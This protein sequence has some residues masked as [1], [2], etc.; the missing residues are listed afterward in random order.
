MWDGPVKLDCFICLTEVSGIHVETTSVLA[1]SHVYMYC[2]MYLAFER[3]GGQLIKRGQL[4]N[5]V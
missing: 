5:L 3:G 2:N 1:N 4:E